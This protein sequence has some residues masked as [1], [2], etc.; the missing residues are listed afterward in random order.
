MTTDLQLIANRENGRTYP[1][2]HPK[3]ASFC[4]TLKST[5]KSLASNT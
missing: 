2:I 3:M 4:Q 1:A 5:G